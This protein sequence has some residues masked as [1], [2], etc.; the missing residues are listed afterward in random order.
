MS[1]V[2]V[3]MPLELTFEM[4]RAVRDDPTACIADRDAWHARLGWLMCA[5]DV[6]VQYRRMPGIPDRAI[7]PPLTPTQR[8]NPEDKPIMMTERDYINATNLAKALAASVI[9][10]DILAMTGQ[11]KL[12]QSDALKALDRITD[13]LQAIVKTKG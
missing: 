11:E 2:T 7:Q 9:V 1:E 3:T 12:D 6:L 8:T 4:M 5:W 10:A 13:R